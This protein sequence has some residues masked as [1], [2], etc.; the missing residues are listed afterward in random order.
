M[1]H[2]RIIVYT[3]NAGDIGGPAAVDDVFGGQ[4]VGRR[5][6]CSAPGAVVPTRPKSAPERAR[7]C[8]AESCKPGSST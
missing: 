5:D 4:Q 6:G 3:D 1:G 2:D 8:G 7:P